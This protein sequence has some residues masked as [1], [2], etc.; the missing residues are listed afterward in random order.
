MIPYEQ[1]LSKKETVFGGAGFEV[2]PDNLPSKLYQFQ[3]DMTRWAIAKGRSAIFADCGLGKSFCQLSWADQILRAHNKDV[4]ILA[5]LAVAPQTVS[6]GAKLGIEVT[7]CRERNDIQRGLN[8]TNYERLEKFADHPWGALVLDESSCLKA[9]DG[10]FRK[11]VTAF[12]RTIPYRLACTA[13]PAPNDLLELSNHAEFLDVLSG[14]EIMALFFKQDGNTTHAWRLKRH[15]HAAFYRWLASWAVAIRKPSDL[16][17]S[18]DGFIL[19]KLSY[20]Q[21]MLETAPPEG[22]LFHPSTLSLQ[23]MRK[24]KRDSIPL[25]VEACAKRV[26]ETN[27]AYVAWCHLNDESHALKRAIPDAEEMLGSDSVERKEELL[28]A[29]SSGQI[30]V[31]ITKPS[32]AGFGLNWQ[33]C[34]RMDFVG[35]DYSYEMFYQAV[36]RSW[37]FG[38]KNP[39]RIGLITS[40]N[41]GPILDAIERKDRQA[42][43]MMGKLVTA[44]RDYAFQND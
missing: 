1:F 3:R 27:G 35:M 10:N 38:Q 7:S 39:V 4:L 31:L 22:F 33:H 25:R 34:A 41:E 44:M 24:V 2:D 36:R 37:R 9:F 14:K 18:D 43:E 19:P 17:Y 12:A 16:G 21:V 13:T 20:E 23:E 6:E 30:R 5:P 32:M 8:I 40:Q 29:F 15:A 42:Q 11:L 28:T 26:S